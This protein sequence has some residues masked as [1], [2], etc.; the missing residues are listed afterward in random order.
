MC[1]LSADSYEGYDVTVLNPALDAERRGIKRAGFDTPALVNQ[2]AIYDVLHAHVLRYLRLYYSSDRDVQAD[3]AVIAWMESLDRLVPNGIR[4]L[5]GDEITIESAARVISAFIYLAT[6]QHDLLG[7]GLWNYQMWTNVQPV[8][9]CK[10]GQR[11]LSAY[12]G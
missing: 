10:N 9:V 5:R 1:K 7:T 4:K 12:S 2:E 11:A 6:V 3:A 8:R